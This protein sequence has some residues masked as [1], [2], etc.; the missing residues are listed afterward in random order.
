MQTRLVVAI[1]SAVMGACLGGSA[2]SARFLQVD[3]VGYKDQVN[4]YAYVDNDPTNKTDP[5]GLYE[6]TGSKSQC[7]AVEAS[8]NR[9]AAALKSDNLSKADRIYRARREGHH[10]YP[11][12]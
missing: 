4:L 9:A 10:Q 11:T 2:A 6:C 1:A 5:T 7:G 3:P 12:E 8:Y